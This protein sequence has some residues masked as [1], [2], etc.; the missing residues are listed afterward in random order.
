MNVEQ[1]IKKDLATQ[2]LNLTAKWREQYKQWHTH[3]TQE[4]Y[5]AYDDTGKAVKML[6]SK[7]LAQRSIKV[8]TAS[9]VQRTV[10]AR[11]ETCF[12]ENG[13]WLRWVDSEN[14]W[15]GINWLAVEELEIC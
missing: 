9:G 8:K 5:N 4:N 15:R 13:Y 6:V 3:D 7:A 12:W 11:A 2:L 14:Y 1:K 10:Q